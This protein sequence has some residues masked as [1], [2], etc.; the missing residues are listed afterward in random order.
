MPL[1]HH[2]F[3]NLKVYQVKHILLFFPSEVARQHLNYS[4]GFVSGTSSWMSLS[5][6]S[7]PG[8]IMNYPLRQRATL[9]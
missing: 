1:I 2:L 7:V 4:L 6:T 5:T 3:L 8:R 9:S